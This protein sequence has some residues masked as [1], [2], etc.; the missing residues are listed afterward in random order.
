MILTSVSITNIYLLTLYTY[1][2]WNCV[3][4]LH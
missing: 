2:S 1:C 4:K 3:I